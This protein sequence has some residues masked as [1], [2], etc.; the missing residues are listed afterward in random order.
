[1][2]DE[3][4]LGPLQ[5]THFRD[6]LLGLARQHE[7]VLESRN[8]ATT[9]IEEH[10]AKF[11]EKEAIIKVLQEEKVELEKETGE[12]VLERD[13][14][15]VLARDQ[16]TVTNEKHTSQINK[17]ETLIKSLEDQKAE[18]EK[19]RARLLMNVAAMLKR[20]K[21]LDFKNR[22]ANLEVKH[23]DAEALLRT[24][25][26]LVKEADLAKIASE[27]ELQRVKDDRSAEGKVKVQ[28]EIE[29]KVLWEKMEEKRE[30][31]RSMI[32]KL[33]SQMREKDK[34]MDAMKDEAG[35]EEE[36]ARIKMKELGDQLVDM[37]KDK[38]TMSIT[39]RGL[40]VRLDE[41]ENLRN[42]NISA[43]QRANACRDERN[44]AQAS[45]AI[46]Q[47]EKIQASTKL[48]H[49]Q[50][51]LDAA[52]A[53]IRKL[54]QDK[55]QLLQKESSMQVMVKPK[56]ANLQANHHQLETDKKRL[57]A[58]IQQAKQ[59]I[60]ELETSLQI[61][62]ASQADHI[63][64]EKE[65]VA[66][67]ILATNYMEQRDKAR[68]DL[69]KSDE[70]KTD[71]RRN[72]NLKSAEMSR[73]HAEIRRLKGEKPRISEGTRDDSGSIGEVEGLIDMSME[74]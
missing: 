36:A 26:S 45:L 2:S 32:E 7:T 47:R 73:L 48:G 61:S 58:E 60:A 65:L 66:S 4:L 13:V 11:Q 6:L 14:A 64:V 18:W 55:N 54:Q 27:T 43:V 38:K 29:D 44:Q 28:K 71:L 39:M 17:A 35:K 3:A 21:T 49:T 37:Q 20:E 16:A 23:A 68:K 31:M 46:A 5:D 30:G 53:T 8:S 74:D 33:E 34:D 25:Q 41:M 24:T 63:S 40:E 62:D 59:R 57:E 50:T 72:S 51:A 42:K 12:L 56:L 15:A 70:A 10:K 9:I 52:A 69:V 1:M 22:Y 19:E 67:K